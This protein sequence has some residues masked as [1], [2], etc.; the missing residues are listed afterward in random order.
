VKLAPRMSYEHRLHSRCACAVGH[1]ET[2][3]HAEGRPF[4]FPHTSRKFERARPFQ[5]EHLA[6]D[7]ALDVPKHAVRG[8]ATLTVRRVDPDA[9]TLV[10]DAIGFD[11]ASIRLGPGDA[12]YVYDGD[13]IHVTVPKNIGRALVVITYAATPRRGLYFLEPDEHYPNRPTQVWSQCQEEDARHFIPCHDKPHV[14]MT[15]EMR[16]KVPAGWFA[17][18]NGD[19]VTRTDTPSGVSFHYRLDSPHPSY[20]LTLVA[21][22]FAEIHAEAGSVPLAYYVPKGLIADGERSFARTPDMVQYFSEIT[23]VPYPW[24]RYSQI[25]VSDFIFGGMENT[26]AT[27]MYEHVLYDARAALDVT[28]DDLVSHEL[29]HQWFGDYVTCRDWPEAWLNE[30]FATYMEHVYREKHL[31]RDEYFYGVKSDLDAYVAEAQGRYRRAIVCRDYDAPLDLFDRH[32]YEKGGLVLHMLRTEL[33]G[34]LFWGGIKLYLTR[35]ARGVVET[36]D[37][38]RALEEVSGRSLGRFFEQWVYQPGHPELD[39]EITWEKEILTVSAKQQQPATDN[40]A[41]VFDLTLEVD[42]VHGGK[43]HRHPLEL[44]ARTEVFAIPCKTRPD[45]VVVDPRGRILGDVRVKAPNDLLRAQLKGGD[46]ARARWLAVKPLARSGDPAT[47]RALGDALTS[48]DEFWGVRVEAAHALGQV[49]GKESYDILAAAI[50]AVHPKVRRAVVETLGRWKTG[51]AAVLLLKHAQKDASYLVEAESARA[52]GKTRQS[53][54]FDALV[55]LLQRDSWAD[56]VRGGAIDGLAASRDDR[57]LPHLVARTRYGNP[58]RV[59]RAAIL[60]L[61]KLSQ[62]K[63]TRDVLEDLLDDADPLLRLDVARALSELGDAKAVGALRAR[64]DVDNDARAK[65]RMRE[66]V[67]DLSHEG[68]RGGHASKDEVD[69]LESDQAELRARLAALEARV[70]GETRG[71]SS[72]KVTSHEPKSKKPSGRSDKKK[73][74]R[75]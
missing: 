25:V 52:L 51:D 12:V 7:L 8:S 17:L 46:G 23:G 28:S 73:S 70:T 32:L 55:D 64:I 33:G 18:S 40:V 66:A 27:T 2:E 34:E 20:L 41:L 21:G 13:Q 3:R 68:K 61:P 22:D 6:L 60:A 71:A 39:V 45:F 75:R 24:A 9:E 65:R 36:R 44:G 5:V 15:T 29:A 42:I 16:V 37:L 4:A 63:K 31:G 49:R 58:P 10:L 19:L 67:R 50:T 54:S 43:A 57:A 56:V 38:M 11:I 30:G 53:S 72:K 62:D 14:K 35:H 47:L 59:R 1:S 69:K 26:T 48:E 74:A